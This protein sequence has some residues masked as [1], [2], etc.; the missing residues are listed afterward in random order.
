MN[1]NEE[2]CGTKI[3]LKY[4]VCT[5]KPEGAARERVFRIRQIFVH[6]VF[7]VHAFFYFYWIG[8]RLLC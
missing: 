1:V 2:K 4:G 5:K 6:E 8:G 7:F 3:I